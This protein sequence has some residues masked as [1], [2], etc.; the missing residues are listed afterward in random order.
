MKLFISLFLGLM[1]LAFSSPLLAQSLNL[2][3]SYQAV[4]RDTDGS[5]SADAP[6]NVRFALHQGSATGTVLYDESQSLMTNQFGLVNTVIGSGT[7]SVGNWAQ[8]DWSEGPYF[9]EVF[10][11]GA[12]VGS[13]QLES[14]PYAKMATE[15]DL[16][17]LKDVTATPPQNGEVLKWNGSEWAPATDLSGSGGGSYSA[18]SG[19]SIS[20]STISNTAPDQTVS[21]NGSGATSVSGSYPNFTISSTDQVNDADSD[22]LNERQSLS[23][24]GSTL[25]LSLGGGSVNLPDNSV[26]NEVNNEAHYIGNVGIGVTDPGFDFHLVGNSGNLL[27]IE[28][29]ASGSSFDLIE[30]QVDTSFTGQFLE[31]Q[32]GTQRV[33]QVHADG[34]AEFKNVT[35]DEELPSSLG[36]DKGKVYADGLPIAYGHVSSNGTILTDY[37]VHTVSRVSNGVYNVTCTKSWIG[38]PVILVTSYATTPQV[39]VATVDPSFGGNNQFRVNISPGDSNFFFLVYGERQ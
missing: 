28:H 31:L 21:I 36:P 2:G 35:V 32:Q 7:P 20:G 13:Q 26:W 34:S 8:V 11:N 5:P 1:L 16:A 14:V 17:H 3:L 15:M 38:Q 9:L 30:M 27:H 22:P 6:A 19:I 23:L 39:E 33:V 25:S 12:S 4:V 29:T 24:N 37:G 18:G 10:L